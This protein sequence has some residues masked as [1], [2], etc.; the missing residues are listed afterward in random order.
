[1]KGVA[2]P[3]TEGSYSTPLAVAGGVTAL[4]FS[5]AFPFSFF[6][7]L[8]KALTSPLPYNR[9]FFFVNPKQFALAL[10]PS[11]RTRITLGLFS[12]P[13]EWGFL[14]SGATWVKGLIRMLNGRIPFGEVWISHE[15]WWVFFFKG[16]KHFRWKNKFE[17]ARQWINFKEVWISCQA[18]VAFNHFLK[19]TFNSIKNKFL[20]EN[21]SY[22]ISRRNKEEFE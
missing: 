10:I 4:Y 12:R 13:F 11:L 18:K 22:F 1:V 21:K 9:H 16:N 15:K 8:R 20:F 7:R 17:L 3:T 5:F 19:V 14:V 2:R 6:R